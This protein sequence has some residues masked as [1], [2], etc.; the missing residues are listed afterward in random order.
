MLEYLFKD[1]L[2]DGGLALGKE[3]REEETR[4]WDMHGREL[5][6]DPEKEGGDDNPSSKMMTT[7]NGPLTLQE[8][9]EFAQY[10][11]EH[12]AGGEDVE[13]DLAKTLDL[14]ACCR[15]CQSP[16]A[17]RKTVAGNEDEESTCPKCSPPSPPPAPLPSS[18]SSSA[19]GDEHRRTEADVQVPTTTATP[20][21][22]ESALPPPPLPS[23]SLS[24]TTE[25]AAPANEISSV[26]DRSDEKQQQQHGG[27]IAKLSRTRKRL[28]RAYLMETAISSSS[29]SSHSKNTHRRDSKVYRKGYSTSNNNNNSPPLVSEQRQRSSSS[30][31]AVL[32]C[33]STLK[34]RWEKQRETERRLSSLEASFVSGERTA[35]SLACIL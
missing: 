12:V 10:Y 21:N 19:D 20:A 24:A 16:M 2:E 3:A 25:T 27:G 9:Q 26:D 8:E 13:Q 22:S 18:A 17:R 29:P 28:L 4:W 35:L 14:R 32:L 34:R 33:P 6:E 23:P 30:S 7:M 15:R 11:W 31:R 5:R 1:C